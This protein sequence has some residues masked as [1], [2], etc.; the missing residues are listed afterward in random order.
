[1]KYS[2]EIIAEGPASA[3]WQVLG[4]RFGDLGWSSTIAESWLDTELDVGVSRT[5][6][7]ATSF[8]PFPPSVVTEKLTHFDRDAMELRYEATSGIPSFILKASNHWRIE[9]VNA[10]RCRILSEAEVDFAWWAAPLAW[11]FPMM[12][13]NDMSRFT[14][15]LKRA[16]E[17]ESSCAV[18]PL[19]G[20]A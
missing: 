1:M 4:E 19:A 2:T 16:V 14:E 13:K 7:S 11:L 17:A 10:Q 15:E 12:I 6:R 18:Q 20:A 8:G 5:C 9:A 3:A